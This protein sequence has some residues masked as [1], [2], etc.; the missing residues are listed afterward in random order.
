MNHCFIFSTF[1][2]PRF[3]WIHYFHKVISYP[4]TTGIRPRQEF[5]QCGQTHKDGTHRGRNAL[6]RTTANW[7]F[8]FD[9]TKSCDR[10]RTSFSSL[11]SCVTRFSRASISFAVCDW[12][13]AGL[14]GGRCCSRKKRCLQSSFVVCT[15]SESSFQIV[16]QCIESFTF[17]P[18]WNPVVTWVFT[19]E[20]SAIS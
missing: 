8:W 2:G 20:C 17:L 3:V 11:L 16:S 6:F 10:K 18:G 1:G 12:L 9:S 14:A 7:R 19:A 15:Y 13:S 5:Y 4:V